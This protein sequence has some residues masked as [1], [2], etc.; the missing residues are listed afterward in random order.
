MK[1]SSGILLPVFSLPGKYGI[2]T[3]GKEAYEFINFL[4][5]SAQSYWQILPLGPTTYGDSPYQTFSTF[6][7]SYV[8]LDLEDLYQN[9]LI[10][11]EELESQ[12]KNDEKVDYVSL[13]KLRLPLLKVA[14]SRFFKKLPS[15]YDKFLKENEDWLPHYA[16]F[17]ALKAYYNETSFSN[18]DKDVIN[19]I[20]KEEIKEAIYLDEN[21]HLFI[22]YSFFKQWFK[23]KSYANSQG[24]KIIGDL[25]IYVSY[26][27]S[28]VWQNPR[29]FELDE[30]YKMTRIAGCPP[31]AFSKTGQLWGNP[32]YNYS[33]MKKNNYRWWVRRIEFSL[34]LFDVLRIDHFRGFEAFFAIPSTDKTAVNGTWVKGPG[35]DIFECINKACKNPNIILEDLGY[36][37]KEVHE[38]LNKT[39]FPGMRVLEFAF[40]GNKDNAYLPHNYIENTVCYTGTHDNMPLVGWVKTLS[41]AQVDQIFTMFNIEK[42]DEIPDALIKAAQNSLASLVI[43]PLQDYLH[44]GEESRINTPSTVGNNW[45]YRIKSDLLTT[46]ESKKINVLTKKSFR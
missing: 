29:N 10:T 15:D 28:D 30:N 2:G 9:N 24:I 18:W 7:G 8:Y 43:I 34:K 12:I 22:Q 3:F 11:K 35:Y 19:G 25:P 44:L 26:D 6:A 40:D 41:R 33:V 38:L 17:M 16:T 36:L 14:S 31:D 45:C 32:L 5:A 21:M 27:S 1:R 39:G 46:Q 20:I 37:T 42:V 4:K 13:K 23:L